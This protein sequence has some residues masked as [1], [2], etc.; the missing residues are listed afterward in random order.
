M[1]PAQVIEIQTPKNFVL[2][3]LWFGTTKPKRVIILV[4]GLF[5]SAFSMQPLVSE[6]VDDSTAVVTFNNRGHDTVA[7]V[8]QRV[9][10]ERK[11][12]RAGAAHEVFTDCVDDIDGALRFVRAQGIK[13]VY[14]AGHSTGCQKIVYYAH[15][16]GA[17]GVLGLILLAPLS[18]Y[19]GD[20]KKPQL[21]KAIAVAKRMVKA[22]KAHEL[23][24]ADMWWHYV[25][26][27][28]FLSLYTPD[29]IE[30]VFCYAQPDKKP[31]IYTSVTKPMI[32]FFA[33]ADEY[34]ERPA[35]QLVEWFKH[36]TK[37]SRYAS[38][39]IKEVGH[40]FKGGEVQVVRY[41]LNWMNQ[42]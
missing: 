5:S 30:E 28:R 29:S 6:L 17:R 34:S 15:K 20:R 7:D 14:L 33:G 40:S 16:T 21:R 41:I 4:H 11:Y 22:G 18:D 24:P 1:Q 25:D 38:H 31:K 9:G 3:G 12:H 8:K 36:N 26:A 27:Q 39:V 13:N 2:N 35:E 32:A 42:K 23:L 19:A 10:T 37:S